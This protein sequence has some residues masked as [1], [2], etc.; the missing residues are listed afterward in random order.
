M[1]QNI[2]FLAKEVNGIFMQMKNLVFMCY[3]TIV[4]WYNVRF[5]QTSRL[6]IVTE[7]MITSVLHQEWLR[8]IQKVCILVHVC[9]ALLF[10]HLQ[11]DNK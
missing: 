2:D 8:K 11:S 10:R 5:S 3:E 1:E 4:I 7:Y 6:Q 9:D